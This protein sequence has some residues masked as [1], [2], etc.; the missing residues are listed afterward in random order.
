MAIQAFHTLTKEE[1]DALLSAPALVTVIVAGADERIDKKEATWAGKLV[2]YRSFTAEEELNPYYQEVGPRFE[3]DLTS[4]TQSWE[5]EHASALEAKLAETKP[6]IAKLD[7]R[8]AT[9]LVQSW[10]TLARQIAEASGGLM[11]FGSVDS[12][13]RKVVDLPM[14][15]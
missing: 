9:L 2:Q 10:R 12:D 14:L 1:S 8:Y 5:P 13:E 15:D 4:L 6:I 3:A 7:A 11:G